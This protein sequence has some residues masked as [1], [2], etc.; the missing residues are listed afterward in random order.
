MMLARLPE[1]LLHFEHTR[2]ESPLGR[3]TFTAAHPCGPLAGG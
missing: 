2:H 1:G 3:W